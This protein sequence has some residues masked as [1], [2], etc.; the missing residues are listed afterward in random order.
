MDQGSYMRIRAVICSRVGAR[1]TCASEKNLSNKFWDIHHWTKKIMLHVSWVLCPQKIRVPRHHLLHR[2]GPDFQ[3]EAIWASS[4]CP[5]RLWALT[6]RPCDPCKCDITQTDTITRASTI[7][8]ANTIAQ[9]NTIPTW[10]NTLTHANGALSEKSPKEVLLLWP[11]VLLESLCGW[12]DCGCREGP[13]PLS[14]LSQP[15]HQANHPALFVCS[16]HLWFLIL[17]FIQFSNM[18]KV[19]G[20]R[21]SFSSLHQR[22]SL[23]LSFPRAEAKENITFSFYAKTY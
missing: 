23:I 8:W 17:L 5:S 7:T 16:A 22:S 13:R 1:D 11:Q 2:P 6:L 18:K 9:A 4:L 20:S 3:L 10:A 19:R 12:Q 21:K 15:D 14:S